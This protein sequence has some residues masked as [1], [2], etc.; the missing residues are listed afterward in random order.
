MQYC[1]NLITLLSVISRCQIQLDNGKKSYWSNKF[2]IAM[3]I[4]LYT[5]DDLR[6]RTAYSLVSEVTGSIP[7]RVNVENSTYIVSGLGKFLRHSL[8]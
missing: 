2:K 6:S 1:F 3:E 5:T 7:G 8:R 4:T